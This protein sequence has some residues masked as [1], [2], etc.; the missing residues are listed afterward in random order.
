[1]QETRDG[2]VVIFHDQS[3]MRLCGVEGSI[4][5]YLYEELPSLCVP[6]SL[7]SVVDVASNP[8]SIRI[9]LLVEVLRE[10][11]DYPMQI[12][13]KNGSEDLVKLVG[14]MILKYDRAH[15]TVW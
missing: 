15:I 7:C 5:D 3:L 1:M 8:D 4:E 9:P 14:E 6:D 10:F 12:D 2:K 11:P 13:V